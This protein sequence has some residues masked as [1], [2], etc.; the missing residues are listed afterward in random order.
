MRNVRFGEGLLTVL[1]ST[2]HGFGVTIN[3]IPTW[4]SLMH[5]FSPVLH[6][7]GSAIVRVSHHLR[8]HLS[9]HNAHRKTDA[10]E[11]GLISHRKHKSA[12]S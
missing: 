12:D 11:I 10:S 8:R 9:P 6:P 4:F 5:F 1:L 7:L 2:N 3:Q